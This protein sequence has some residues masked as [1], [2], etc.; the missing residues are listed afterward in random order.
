MS[1]G[2][3]WTIRGDS[4]ELWLDV[5]L[6]G[7]GEVDF[8]VFWKYWK[9]TSSPNTCKLVLGP[10]DWSSDFFES[11][12]TI[13]GA[14]KPI[15]FTENAP[16]KKKIRETGKNVVHKNCFFAIVNGIWEVW[17]CPGAWHGPYEAIPSNFG[18]VWSYMAWSIFMF[19]GNIGNSLHHQIPPNWSSGLQSG[20]RISFQSQGTISR[21]IKPIIF[22]QM[23]TTKNKI[24]KTGQPPKI[25][26]WLPFDSLF[27][28]PCL[29]WAPGGPGPQWVLRLQ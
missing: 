17:G 18:R 14:T 29:F 22:Q 24:R 21:A 6:H 16:P 9:L 10:P 12:G 15:N 1:R 13:S 3:A 20:P 7:M 2:V 11:Q 23:T 26:I 19:L 25:V 27:W 28:A 5:V 8:H 4:P